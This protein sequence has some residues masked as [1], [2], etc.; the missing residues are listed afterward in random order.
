MVV[1]RL[2]T[3]KEAKKLPLLARIP[4]KRNI[5]SECKVIGPRWGGYREDQSN[6]L[7][8]S[9]RKVRNNDDCWDTRGWVQWDGTDYAYPVQEGSYEM[10]VVASVLRNDDLVRLIG[11]FY[12]EA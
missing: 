11:G 4:Q 2:F 3:M 5:I 9:M 12:K 8:S 7:I 1:T 10:K 6:S